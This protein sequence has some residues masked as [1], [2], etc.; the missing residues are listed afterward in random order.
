MKDLPVFLKSPA[1][2]LIA[3]AVIV[4]VGEI[5]IMVLIASAQPMIQK[6]PLLGQLVLY[7]DPLALIAIIL[8]ALYF[9][10]YRPLSRQAEMERQLDHLATRLTAEEKLAE[11]ELHFRS[12]T[13]SAH[14]A[15]ITGSGDGRI[16]GWNP[17]AERL[18][19]HTEAEILGKPISELMPERFRDRH[20]ERL[21]MVKAGEPV[22]LIGKMSEFVGLRKDGSEFPLELSMSQWQTAQGQFFNAIIRDIS[23]RK[24]AENVIHRLAFY[25]ELT[26]LPNRRLLNERL[27]QAMSASKRSGRYGAVMFL[28][29]DRFKPLNDT[30]G[31]NVGD[32]LLVEV[33]RRLKACLREAD[34]VARFGGDEFVV[35]LC[36][37]DMAQA[38]AA[39][40]ASLVAGKIRAALAEP[41]LLAVR[42]RGAAETTVE[43][44]CTSSIGVELFFGTEVGA[45]DLI[46]FADLA[47]YQA[48][49]AG[50]NS[51]RFRHPLADLDAKHGVSGEV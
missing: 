18:F 40:Q 16:V 1:R 47:M 27:E 51:I 24:Q 36:E 23:G 26:Q 50:R 4:L 28:D 9:L 10:I 43:H 37:L 44:R 5:L 22:R 25:D 30:Y 41:Y 49:D 45:E 42:K 8:P 33:A 17:A 11:S 14:D 21:A 6:H 48:K 13:E 2:V 15:I 46:R 32:L 31:H 29:L 12:V 19:G 35:M 7:L 34:T 3:M 38:A 20:A 39:A